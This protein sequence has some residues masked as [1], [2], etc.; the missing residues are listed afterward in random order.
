M[1]A[2][3]PQGESITTL[4]LQGLKEIEEKKSSA[5]IEDL[6]PAIAWERVK[7]LYSKQASFHCESDCLQFCAFT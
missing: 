6:L 1:A 2:S 3:S 5:S 4:K 7:K